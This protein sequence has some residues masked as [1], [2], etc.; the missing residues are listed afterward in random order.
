MGLFDSWKEWGLPAF[1]TVLA[2][3]QDKITQVG[4]VSDYFQPNLSV[5]ASILSPLAAMV[6]YSQL[7]KYSVSRVNRISLLGFVVFTLLLTSCFVFSQV[8]LPSIA[9]TP[10][11]TYIA[12]AS[13]I[14]GYLVTFIAFSIAV[15]ASWIVLR[16]N[17]SN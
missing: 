11:F 15:M 9:L 1:A 13:N 17:G 16:R 14:V 6:T 2:P 10:K 4:L 3:W 8:I 5:A 12:W 7:L